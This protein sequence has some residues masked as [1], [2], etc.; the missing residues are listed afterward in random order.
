VLSVDLHVDHQELIPRQTIC[1]HAY[2]DNHK[3]YAG[4]Y[5]TTSPMIEIEPLLV[6]LCQHL[7]LMALSIAKEEF[8]ALSNDIIFGTPTS[9][10]F[11]NCK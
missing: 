7:N 6:E 4:F 10:R 5:D 1:S 3:G 9:E 8:M 11:F 2:C